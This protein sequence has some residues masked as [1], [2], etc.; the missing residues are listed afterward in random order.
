MH[1]IKWVFL[2]S[3]V[4][5]S[6]LIE[7]NHFWSPAILGIHLYIG[8]AITTNGINNDLQTSTHEIVN[9]LL[10]IEKT[11]KIDRN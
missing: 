9:Y 3:F 6:K 11:N 1:K 2:I 10:L 5:K 8:H 4:Q 7:K